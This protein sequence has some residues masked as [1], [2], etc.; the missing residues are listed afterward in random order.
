MIKCT[1]HT[2]VHP[3]GK[4][5]A[6]SQERVCTLAV[7]TYI[8]TGSFVTCTGLLPPLWALTTPNMSWP[9]QKKMERYPQNLSRIQRQT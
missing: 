1:M 5:Y 3:A 8:I 4:E 9:Q 7:T 6:Q 2:L